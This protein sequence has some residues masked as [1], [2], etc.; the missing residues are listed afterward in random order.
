MLHCDAGPLG[1][2][3]ADAKIAR[4]C[5]CTTRSLPNEC[6]VS[7]RTNWFWNTRNATTFKSLD[8]LVRLYY[9]SVGHGAV[10]LLNVTPDVT[11]LI[12]QADAKR[13]AEF[14]AEIRRRFGKSLAETKGTGPV[15]ALILEK[16]T[17]IDHVVIM[18][19]IA[20]GERIRQCI[21][22]GPVGDNDF[23][24]RHDGNRKTT[25]RNN[26]GPAITW[27]VCFSGNFRQLRLGKAMQR[28]EV[29]TWN[30]R[31][32]SY[33]TVSVA[34]AEVVTAEAYGTPGADLPPPPSP[35][36][37]EET[38]PAPQAP[39]TYYLSDMKW[40]YGASA[41]G[42]PIKLDADHDGK[43]ITIGGIAY[44]RG[45]GT[46]AS[47][48]IVYDLSKLGKTY[49]RFVSDVGIDSEISQGGS[50]VFQVYADDE[51]RFDSGVM[52]A[53]SAVK[54]VNVRI[55]GAK[56][57]RLVVTDGG[58]GINSDHADWAGARLVG[59]GSH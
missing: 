58:D 43:P 17:W 4:L 35:Q 31:T 24:V 59:G 32:I 13:C 55:G 49:A 12:P 6:D 53:A 29:T 16:P 38:P 27:R 41:G 23:L 14:G 28:A 19:D 54:T 30:G 21:V 36:L 50:V 47:S 15:V 48:E 10:L 3:W 2:A 42:R 20:Q 11:G 46:H 44:A 52:T 51:K 25:L 34:P 45:L 1:P 8:D 22:E 56:R 5:G 26:K 39:G 9:R 37:E 40:R 7:I 33:V 18:E 57:L